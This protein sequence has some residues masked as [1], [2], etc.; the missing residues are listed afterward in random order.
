MA[1]C[2]ILA[3]LCVGIEKYSH[4]GLSNLPGAGHDAEGFAK[5]LCDRKLPRE[6]LYLLVG[7]VTKKDLETSIDNFLN[8]IK[9]TLRETRLGCPA[10]VVVYIAAHGRECQTSELPAI[11]PSDVR[12]LEILDGLVNL[13]SLLITP[14]DS[15]KLEGRKLKVWLTIDT[16]RENPKI[17]TWTGNDP[18][19]VKR[20]HRRSEVDFQFFFACDRG[21][22]A[23]NDHSLAG[24]LI[25]ALRD[26]KDLPD[27]RFWH[28]I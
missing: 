24:A 9:S 16:C 2:P 18:R 23:N 26:Y 5:W 20:L 13:D 27:S 12:S 21:R 25:D 14:L 15:I 19:Q 28:Q 3:A 11:L 6:R 17:R 7:K 10:L 8:L 1:S 4:E 22:L